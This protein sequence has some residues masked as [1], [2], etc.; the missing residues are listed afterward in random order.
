MQILSN[1]S[2]YTVTGLDITAPRSRGDSQSREI[3][4]GKTIATIELVG[5]EP[6]APNRNPKLYPLPD[7]MLLDH[8]I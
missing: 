3:I 2:I 7:H 8:V 4:A 6:S 5:Y 1:V